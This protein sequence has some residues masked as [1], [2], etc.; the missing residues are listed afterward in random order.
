MRKSHRVVLSA[1]TVL[2]LT[3]VAVPA[4]ATTSVVLDQGHVDV[5][6]IAW[7]DNAFN[8][9]VHDEESATEYTPAEVQLVAKPGAQI[10]VP[11]DPAYAFLGAPGSPAWVLPQV[12]DPELLWPGIGSEEIASGVFTNDALKVTLVGVTGP[13]DFSI[14]TTDA[15]GTPTR[16]ADSGNG[17]PDAINTTAGGH[18]HANWAFEA[19]GTYKLKFKVSGTLAATGKK[20]TSTVATYTF[21]VQQ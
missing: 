8:V 20:V 7:E 5:V 4:T 21:K 15:F 16:L 18:L 6:G 10:A 1:A 3:G 12:Q 2:A 17:L 9:H 19:A 13:A 11:N 14:F